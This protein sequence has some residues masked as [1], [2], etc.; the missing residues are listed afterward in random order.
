MNVAYQL[1]DLQKL[2]NE[3]VV[4]IISSTLEK[5]YMRSVLENMRKRTAIVRSV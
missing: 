2:C 1:A 4:L 3:V 5:R